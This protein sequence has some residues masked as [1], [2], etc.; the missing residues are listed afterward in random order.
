MLELDFAID[1]TGQLEASHVDLYARF[2]EWIRQCYETTL[3]KAATQMK[4]Q[5][6]S[7][8]VEV[9]AGAVFD[10]V[11]LQEDQRQGQLIRGWVVEWSE[12]GGGTWREFA[13]GAS[14]GS[15]RIEVAPGAMTHAATH[16]RLNITASYGALKPSATLS[17]HAPCP[18]GGVSGVVKLGTEDIGMTETT[19]IVWNHSLYRFESVRGGNWNNTLNCTNPAPGEAHACN[20]YLRFR[21]QSGPPEWRTLEVVTAPFGVGFG[22]ACAVVDPENDKIWA[23]GSGEVGVFD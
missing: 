9:P 6:E 19:P 22:L 21:R 23:F 10:R 3:G 17:V 5:I 12:D 7:A 11:M 18:T 20:A 16:V 14:I 1:R 4:G 8:T 13:K 15:K 2:G